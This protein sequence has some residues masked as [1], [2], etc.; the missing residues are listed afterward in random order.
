MRYLKTMTQVDS[1]RSEYNSLIMMRGQLLGTL[2]SGP[3]GSNSNPLKS[4]AGFSMKR[5][6]SWMARL[7]FTSL[8]I[9][10]DN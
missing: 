10:T 2:L 7:S 9:R 1:N 4:R 6:S 5:D 8:K 3:K